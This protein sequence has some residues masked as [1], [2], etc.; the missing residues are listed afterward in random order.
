[1]ADFLNPT[2]YNTLEEAP[3]VLEVQQ[4]Q[5]RHQDATVTSGHGSYSDVQYLV[6]PT[7]ARKQ[8]A[9]WLTV[10][11]LMFVLFVGTC[12]GLYQFAVGNN[13]QNVTSNLN[14]DSQS[15]PLE[16]ISKKSISTLDQASQLDIVG[17]VNVNGTLRLSQEDRPVNPQVGTIYLDKKDQKMYYYNGST[18]KEFAPENQDLAGRSFAQL[19][20]GTSPTA[21][22]GNLAVNGSVTAGSFN[23]NGAGLSSLSATSINSGT[24]GN[25]FL[26]GQG[27]I[28]I[29]A[30]TGVSGGGVVALGGSTNISTIYGAGSN[31]SVRGSTT[32]T[33]PTGTGNL[34]G[35]GNVVT[36]GN[37]GSCGSLNVV[38]NP[39]FNGPV[40]LNGSILTNNGSTLFSAGNS[41]ND[42][43]AGGPIGPAITTVDVKTSFG[44]SQ[45]TVGQVL[46]LPNP[47][48]PVA[49]RIVYVFNTGSASFSM[50][51]VTIDPNTSQGYIFTGTVWTPSNVDV[52][53]SGSGVT[54]VGAVSGT[55]TA[56]GATIVGT[57]LFLAVAPTPPTPASS[58]P[59]PKP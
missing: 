21:Q 56:N 13:N 29:N 57:T 37:G 19:Q 6:D 22:A 46:T 38:S 34:T 49:G 32:I 59:A 20:A 35:G 17:T 42:Y 47:S 5:L 23:G 30:G 26:T 40:S 1:M 28:T 58:L 50:Y 18:Y 12:F 3:E 44:I 43:P 51:G 9:L 16:D 45:T 10:G 14:K 55:G 48:N 27:A 8:K 31:A 53:G 7:V 24:L 36:L 39:T 33:C 54:S 25:A 11:S 52:G 15:I 4:E 2:P 41:L